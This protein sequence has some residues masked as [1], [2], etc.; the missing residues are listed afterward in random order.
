MNAERLPLFQWLNERAAGVLMHPVSLPGSTGIGTLGTSARQFVNFLA[1][2]GM[3]YWQV[4]PLGP[5]GFGDSPYQCFSAFAGN[6]YFIDLETLIA[7]GFLEDADLNDLRA[8]PSD[9]VDYGA[10]W[11]LR[12]PVLKKAFRNFADRS[13]AAQRREFRRFRRDQKEWL[14]PYT[15]FIALKGHFGG[16]SWQEWPE[17]L[18]RHTK[19]RKQIKTFKIAE[20]IDAHA[21]FQFQF[22]RQWSEIKQYANARGISL[23][24]DIPIFVAMDSADVWMHPSLFQMNRH[25][26]PT[27]VAGVP[28][29][30]FAADGQLWGNPLYDWPR[31]QATHYIWWLARLKASFE[32]YDV[33]RIDHFRGFDEYCRIPPDAENAR[34]YEWLPGPGLGLFEAM[35]ET[36]PEAKLVAEDLGV[37]TDAVRDLVEKCGFPGMKILQFGF[38]GATEYLPH[39]TIPNSVLYPG[40][41]DNDTARGWY[42]KAS[43]SVQDF[44]RQYLNVP[45]TSAAWD[46]VRAGYASQSR[47]F[48]I[49]L[50]DLLDLGTEARMN[51]PGKPSGNWQWRFTSDQLENLRI[52]K[53]SYLKELAEKTQRNA[54]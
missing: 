26:R 12:W 46:M 40:T 31:H 20:E 19:A 15:E 6:P 29:D 35:K 24:G 11:R 8:L 47:L 41:H 36:F 18:R 50:Q 32:L 2:S 33:V 30:Y 53:A 16:A 43:S 14:A 45:G 3:K 17:E 39:N 49:P 34:A 42:E 37:I 9:R 54:L 5:T 21:W 4:F 25:L 22:F 7:Q 10:Q 23:F 48:M 51:I 38:E 52:G 13:S 1:E 44:F 27:G 28:P